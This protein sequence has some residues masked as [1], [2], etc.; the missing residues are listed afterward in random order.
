MKL[1]ADNLIK[2]EEAE[3]KKYTK[4]K[5]G[6]NLKKG[7]YVHIFDDIYAEIGKGNILAKEKLNKY[8]AVLRKK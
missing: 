6:E 7:D 3:I 2:I 4:L 8:N 1:F 5:E